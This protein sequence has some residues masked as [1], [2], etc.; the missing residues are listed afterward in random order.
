[1]LPSQEAIQKS[2]KKNS[3]IPSRRLAELHG[4][5]DDAF[6][7]FIAELMR[8]QVMGDIVRVP[9]R[10]W[11]VAE[12]VPYRVGV[13]KISRRGHAFVSLVRQEPAGDFFLSGDA[14]GGAFDGDLVLVEPLERPR[15]RR[16]GGRRRSSSDRDARDRLRRGRL[17]DVVKR[18]R[19]PV[20]GRYWRGESGKGKKEHSGFVEPIEKGPAGE[21]YIVPGKTLDAPNGAKVFVRL[22]DGWMYG[23]YARGEITHVVKDEGAYE[24]DL[25]RIVSEFDL[26]CDFSEAEKSASELLS[27]PV[28]GDSW[29]KREDLRSLRTFTID[30]ADA[31]DFDD[32]ISL[33]CLSDGH[34]RLGVHIADV[35]AYVPRGSKLDQTARERGTSVYLPGHVVPM[36]PERISND[37][38][39]L[40]PNEDRLAKS[41]FMDFDTDGQR[42]SCR[43]TASVI[44]SQRRFTYDEALA[45]LECVGDS[46]DPAGKSLPADAADYHEVLQDMARLRDALHRRRVQRGC[47]ELA[48]PS[49]RLRV[50]SGGEVLGV[51]QETRDP[52]HHLIEEFMLA[53]NEA[54]SSFLVEHDLPQ[55]SRTHDEPEEERLDEFLTVLGAMDERYARYR[56]KKTRPSLQKIVDML[57]GESFGGLMHMQLL[58]C[59]PHALYSADPGPHFALAT[60]TYCHFTSPIR[61]YPDLFVH[62]VLDRFLEG[63]E[64]VRSELDSWRRDLTDLASASSQLEQRAEKAERELARL[65]LIRHMAE[66]VGEEMEG[67]IVSLHK[68]GL[69]VFVEKYLFDGF[70]HLSSL[71][72]DFYEFSEESHCL[73]G[74][75]RKNRLR[76]GDQV[77]LV[78]AE[79][80]PDLRDIRFEFLG[81]V[82]QGRE[83]ARRPKR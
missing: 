80:D 53:A 73:V 28:D 8:L 25:H 68:F 34:L 29:P 14:I 57:L 12:R 35:S 6:E 31:K 10:G 2:I 20:L 56:A 64:G 42:L 33:E 60:D 76:L 51:V 11:N 21:I 61:R 66:R 78:L 74:R 46:A 1:M 13:L 77:A 49:V 52:A 27:R 50:A 22:L 43:I 63:G 36:L 67:T 71:N 40:R 30:P 75:R 3:W 7:E 70:V 15:R 82:S 39:S 47:L 48:V 16:V 5:G 9:G 59:M 54:V 41:V 18:R 38:A 32:A 81:K 23:V 83:K 26:P 58:R 45:I 4:V 55:M 44:R 79:L 62:Q 72:D 69:F 37:L 17:V 24:S 19:S 65:L